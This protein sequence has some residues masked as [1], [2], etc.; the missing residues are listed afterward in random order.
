MLRRPRLEPLALTSNAESTRSIE[1]LSETAV[2]CSRNHTPLGNSRASE[3]KATCCSDPPAGRSYRPPAR[4]APRSPTRERA[5]Q[6]SESRVP[7]ACAAAAPKPSEPYPRESMLA[8][9]SKRGTGPGWKRI[10]PSPFGMS[11]P[12]HRKSATC[13]S[14]PNDIESSAPSSVSRSFADPLRASSGVGPLSAL[15][16]SQVA[17]ESRTLRLS[18]SKLNTSVPR[19]GR[20][21][22]SDPRPSVS[23]PGCCNRSESTYRR[24]SA[25]RTDPPPLSTTVP[26]NNDGATFTDMAPWGGVSLSPSTLPVAVHVRRV[27]GTFSLCTSQRCRL[28][29]VPRTV[30]ART[31]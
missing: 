30:N 24:L 3:S 16:A 7:L 23:S 22:P 26:A 14:A 21:Q 18:A 20:L 9:N 8:L 25:K 27:G 10:E 12:R 2:G 19:L 1:S 29:S 17:S 11:Q 4:N 13:A 15:P 6:V 5:N 28:T 31:P